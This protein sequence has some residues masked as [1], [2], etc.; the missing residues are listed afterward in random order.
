[1]NIYS[2]EDA[3]LFTWAYLDGSTPVAINWSSTNKFNTTVHFA[4]DPGPTIVIATYKADTSKTSS[5]E[6]DWA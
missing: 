6:I 3:S 4:S 2:S 5:V 1:M